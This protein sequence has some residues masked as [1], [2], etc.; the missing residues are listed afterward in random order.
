MSRLLLNAVVVMSGLACGASAYAATP[1]QPSQKARAMQAKAPSGVIKAPDAP[2]QGAP[3]PG[4]AM[5]YV[6]HT[7]I[8][9]MAGM[10]Y[11][12][13]DDTLGGVD[14]QVV[15]YN[16]EASGSVEASDIYAFYYD[17]MLRR[18][19]DRDGGPATYRKD[20][21]QLV[22]SVRDDAGILKIHLLLKN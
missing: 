10:I 9:V 12:D 21:Q 8:P 18:G 14:N 1:A 16:F 22:V 17:E 5:G 4:K 15:A 6:P 3:V 11:V 19:W 7:K 2:L 20:D 13:Q